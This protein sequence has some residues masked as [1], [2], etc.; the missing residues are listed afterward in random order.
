MRHKEVNKL[1]KQALDQVKLPSMLE[2]IGLFGKGDNKRQDCLTYTT[3]KNGKCMIW[4]FTSVD[5]LCRLYVKKASTEVGS[6]AAGR[7]GKKVEKYSNLS[8]NY[9]GIKLIKQIGKKQIRK[10][11]V[12]IWAKICLLFFYLKVYQ[13]QYSKAMQFVLWV[14]KYIEGY[15]FWSI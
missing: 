15:S 10:P 8:D 13:W 7:E 3:W 14:S 2:P 1:F 4:N 11:P 12:K 9:Q 6:A 5:T